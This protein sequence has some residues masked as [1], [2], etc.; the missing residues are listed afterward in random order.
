[1][2]FAKTYGAAT[3]S[4]DGVLIEVEADI[5]QGLPGFNIVGLP[6]TAVREAKERVKTAIKNSGIK[7]APRRITIN[8]APANLKKDGCGLDLPIAVAVLAAY[9]FIPQNICRSFLFAGELSFE[10]KLRTI[11]GI[12]PMAICAQQNGLQKF[13]LPQGNENEALLVKDIE[14]FAI[15]SL[16]ELV[17]FLNKRRKFS[18]ATRT[19][20]ISSLPY[21]CDF[22]DVQG[23]FAAKR[24]LEIAA[25]GSHN[26]IMCGP[27]G[28]GKT[29]LA[30]CLPS[31]LPRL[32]PKEALEVTKIYSICGLL[33]KNGGLIERRPFRQPHHTISSAGLIGGGTNPHPGEVTL[34]HNGVLFLDELPEFGRKT[35]ELLRQPLEDRQITITRAGGTFTFPSELILICAYNP[36]PCG[37]FGDLQKSCT[38]TERERRNYARRISGPLLDRIDLRINLSRPA[39]GD[40]CTEK[41]AETSAQI[42]KRVEAAR[43]IQQKRLSAYNLCCN[44]QLTHKLI[45]KLCFLD[46]ASQKIMQTAFTTMNLSARSYDRIIKVARTIADLKECENI[47]SEHIAEAIHFRNFSPAEGQ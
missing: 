23:Q 9:G 22:S 11:S 39:Y 16:A 38:C 20:E 15:T 7:L 30:K 28:T 42:R 27:P 40:L 18:P 47:L 43:K 14:V 8:L 3:A 35:I 19:K 13:I 17:E 46:E 26:V 2:M 45:K 31:I 36:C 37:F 44:A 29:M 41:K 12:L 34:S 4:I 5:C 10:G 24:A 32:S 1:M 21:A 33:P 6:D 25:A